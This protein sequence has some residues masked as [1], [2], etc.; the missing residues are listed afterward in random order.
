MYLSRDSDVWV[1]TVLIRRMHIQ[2]KETSHA[3]HSEG[4]TEEDEHKKDRF[5]QADA[6]E[7]RR[8]GAIHLQRQALEGH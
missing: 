3:Q 8:D 2:T 4:G 6:A 1:E 5:T 7:P